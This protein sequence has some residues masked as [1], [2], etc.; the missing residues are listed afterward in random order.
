MSRRQEMQLLRADCGSDFQK[1][2]KDVQLGGG[3][4]VACLREHQTQLTSLCQSALLLAA[5]PK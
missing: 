5:T 1:F 2:C 3:R 4:A